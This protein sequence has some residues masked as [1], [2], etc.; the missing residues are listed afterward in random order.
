[1]YKLG[2]D[3]KKWNN[4]CPKCNSTIR[5][6]LNSGKDGASASAYCSNSLTA[7]GIYPSLKAINVCSWKGKV[8]RQRDGGVRFRNNDG[9][10]L[11]E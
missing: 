4:K 9:T 5:W 7:S 3:P 10:Y 1:L 11:G 6:H 2:D 8:V